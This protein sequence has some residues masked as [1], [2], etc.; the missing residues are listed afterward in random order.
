MI[1]GYPTR[2]HSTELQWHSTQ[3][4]E[5]WLFTFTHF[6][7]QVRP[8]CVSD[9]HIHN[10][11]NLCFTHSIRTTKFIQ[12]TTIPQK[13]HNWTAG[14]NTTHYYHPP[15]ALN[16]RQN[17]FL[18]SWAVTSEKQYRSLLENAKHTYFYLT[19]Y[20]SNYPNML[21]QWAGR[22]LCKISLSM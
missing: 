4:E 16:L 10:T 1:T 15:L 17:Y 2:L 8:N 5:N 22:I 20:R 13:W 12:I 7:G 21:P 11:Q 14:E 19:S 18:C 9:I 6:C 3:Q